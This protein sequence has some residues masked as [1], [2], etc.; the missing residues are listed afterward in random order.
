[1][2]R[3]LSYA[4]GVMSLG[5]IGLS[6]E[7]AD[8]ATTANGPYYASPSWDQKLPANTRFI[9]LANWNGEAVL[10]R[11]TGLV[12]E[13]VPSTNTT[14]NWVSA[15]TH[16]VTLDKGGRKGWRLP[17][18]NELASLLDSTALDPAL[19]SGHPFVVQSSN[20][21]SATTAADLAG[22]TWFVG[23]H[24]GVVGLAFKSDFAY[25]TWCVRGGQVVDPQ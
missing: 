2:K 24:N 11:E 6:S 23:F 18:I 9:V 5:M 8:A 19:P 25:L 22:L 12:W 1:M 17:T 20:Y 4:L 3:T 15:S 13:K 21:L 10:D 16:C 7:P 14:F